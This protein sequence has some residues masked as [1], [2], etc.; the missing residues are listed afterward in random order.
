MK[1]KPILIGAL[2]DALCLTSLTGCGGSA[3]TASGSAEASSRSS[4]AAASGE[5][6]SPAPSETSEDTRTEE[7]KQYLY[8]DNSETRWETVYAYWWSDSFGNCCNKQTGELYGKEW[9]GLPMEQVEGT[10]I[11]R[12]VIPLKAT[13]IIFNTGVTDEEVVSGK[14]GY[15]TVDLSYDG[16]ANDGQVYKIDMTQKPKKR[17]GR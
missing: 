15:Q 9:P 14:E 7:S 5:A 10:D 16:E 1:T 6:A 4:E 17:H 11:W 3:P 2:A 12:I 8:F 13:K